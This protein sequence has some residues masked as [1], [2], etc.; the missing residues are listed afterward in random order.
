MLILA[1][2]DLGLTLGNIRSITVMV[3]DILVMWFILF[4]AIKVVRG[5]SRTIQ[6]FKGVMLVVILDSIAKNMWLEDSRIL[7]GYFH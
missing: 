2:T 4:Y 7:Y 1:F 3:I 5:N 6:I